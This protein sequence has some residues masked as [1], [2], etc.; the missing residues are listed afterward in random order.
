MDDKDQKLQNQPGQGVIPTPAD[1]VGTFP[2]E[3]E[4][5]STEPLIESSQEKHIINKELAEIGTKE[6][7]QTPQPTQEHTQVGIRVSERPVEPV[8][9]PSSSSVP[10][11]PYMTQAQ[12]I[13]EVKKPDKTN[14]FVWRALTFIRALGKQ[15]LKQ[16]A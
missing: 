3:H 2:K 9:T 8:T 13:T 7:S 15:R 12:A 14:S 4:P 11:D 16:K 5:I 6:I 1:P 10:T